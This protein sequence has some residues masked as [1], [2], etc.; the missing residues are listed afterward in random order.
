MRLQIAARHMQLTVALRDH[1]ERR[2]LDS[3]PHHYDRDSCDLRVEIDHPV[4]LTKRRYEEVHAQL[5][6]PGGL[7]VAHAR[8]KDA[9]AAVDA[10]QKQLLRRIDEWQRRL[11]DRARHPKKYYAA[12]L[13]EDG[14]LPATLPTPS[15]PVE[16]E[17]EP[18]PVA[19]AGAEPLP[20]TP[21]WR[22]PVE[23]LD[24][25]AARRSVR[26]FNPLPIPDAL[27]TALSDALACAPSAGNLESRRFFLVRDPKRRRMLARATR[28]Q[29]DAA[30]GASLL[31]VACAQLCSAS[32][33]HR[34]GVELYAAMDV[35]ASVENLLLA[36]HA[37]GLGAVWIG[38]I[39]E[40][41]VSLVMALP[42]ELRPLSI[43][44]VGWPAERPAPPRRLPRSELVRVI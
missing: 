9:Y 4:G 40:A 39:D 33:Y 14:A 6:V 28:G 20:V 35:A 15:L 22:R 29:S 24:L 37:A 10:A 31:V 17:R 26:R 21:P 30:A 38:E 25:L 23:I 18:E 2:F 16:P 3:L 11:R 19:A 32:L 1:V 42:S 41:E 12:R 13:V 44:A 36:A 7:L 34:R 8:A 5:T 43:V 27:L